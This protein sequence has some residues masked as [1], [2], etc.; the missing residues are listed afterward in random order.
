M[1]GTARRV[2]CLRGYRGPR[3]WG[4]T[5]ARHLG[6]LIAGAI[7]NPSPPKPAML[8]PPTVTGPGGAQVPVEMPGAFQAR[9]PTAEETRLEQLQV[10]QVEKQA[11]LQDEILGG[12]ERLY[13][14][15]FAD[16]FASQVY[17]QSR[18]EQARFRAAQPVQLAE[19]GLQGALVAEEA[20]GPERREALRTAY[21]AALG[22]PPEVVAAEQAKREV[23]AARRGDVTAGLM[24]E[25]FRKAATGAS[26]FDPTLTQAIGE[27]R[28]DL[29]SR[30][31]A[32]L[33]PGWELSTPGQRAKQSLDQA[34]AGTLY[35]ARRQEIAS[36][37]GPG[38]YAA[39]PGPS[40]QGLLASGRSVSPGTF[41]P[42]AQ[43]AGP[44]GTTAGLLGYESSP[45]QG[46]LGLSQ[47][48]GQERTAANQLAANIYGTQYRGALEAG[49]TGYRS[50]A[51]LMRQYYADQAA[52]N[53]A[54]FAA[55]QQEASQ[56]IGIAAGAIF[57]G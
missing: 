14:R 27:A 17:E 13:G 47:L 4:P 23:E 38:L 25:R 3:P 5:P 1:D 24:F 32:Q 53:R 30:M 42:V 33:G 46:A 57:G 11:K 9:E 28:Q 36:A 7:F 39:Q 12:L 54:R 34:I 16:E 48:L 8:P 29:D 2:R 31:R 56:G 6:T 44:M 19:I 10:A 26:D 21:T 55:G 45:L 22:A 41:A 51:D 18:A 35:Q 40:T 37:L 43:Q 52:A 49:L 20:K 50:N 15:S